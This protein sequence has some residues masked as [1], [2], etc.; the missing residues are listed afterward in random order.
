MPSK[1]DLRHLVIGGRPRATTR[2]SMLVYR[3]SHTDRPKNAKYKGV[4]VR[5]TRDEFI[6]WFQARDF[7]GCTVDRIDCKGH[8]ELSNMQVITKLQNITKDH[9]K[10]REGYC[11]CFSCKE[12][13]PSEAFSTDKRR[14]NGKATIC[15]AC[16][17]VRRRKYSQS[18]R[19]TRNTRLPT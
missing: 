2:Y 7:E 6:P 18:K 4:E 16:D 13:K 14:A 3:V 9:V 17:V 11:E 8:Y 1:P 19:A 15:K 10:H 12:V 5:V